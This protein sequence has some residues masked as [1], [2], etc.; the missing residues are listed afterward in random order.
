MSCRMNG[1]FAGV[2]SESCGQH[3][4]RGSGVVDR[5]V[6]V[7]RVPLG[8]GLAWTI[9]HREPVVTTQTAELS[10]DRAHAQ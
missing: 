1:R 6:V 2:P 8:D 5:N 4:R 3:H 9:E 10:P 7:Q